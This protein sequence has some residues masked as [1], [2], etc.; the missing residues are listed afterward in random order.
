MS[1]LGTR[2]RMIPCL[3]STVVSEIGHQES[4]A[5]H[6]KLTPIDNALFRLDLRCP[7][8]FGRPHLLRSVPMP[9]LLSPSTGSIHAEVWL[10]KPR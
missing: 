1:R 3:V 6:V 4:A 9:R 7:Y 2:E 10:A 5:A 8:C